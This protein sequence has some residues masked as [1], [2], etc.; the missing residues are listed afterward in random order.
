MKD[1]L[2]Q[3]IDDL[4]Q[5]N[6]FR[7]PKGEF[8]EGWLS[9]SSN[10]YLGLAKHPAVVEAAIKATQKYGVGAGASR[11]A[12]GNYPLYDEFE[13]KIAAYKGY[14]AACVFGSGYLTNIGVIQA[15]VGEKD[16]I[17]AD[18]LSH[19]CI[20]DGARLSGAKL[21]RFKHNDPKHLYKLLLDHR[22]KFKT[23]LVVTEEIFSMDGDHAP[24]ESLKKV[25]VE[26]GATL[27]VDGAHS[28]YEPSKQ[29]NADIYV[30]TMSKALGGYGGYVCGS[31]TFIEYIKTA[32]R[33]LIYSTALPPSVL[34]AAIKSLEVIAQEKPYLKTLENAKYLCSLL[35]V[36]FSNSSIIPII[37]GAEDAALRFEKLLYSNK[38]L[39]SAIRP[40]TV[41]PNT[42]RLRVSVTA[43]HKNEELENLAK[44]LKT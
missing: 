25:C 2:Q 15:L 12:G 44:L 9:F 7:A 35:G 24:L 27:M 30:G 43:N 29:H 21:L 28:L 31:K 8:G 10:D 17:I 3:K 19:A 22:E 37:L 32:A 13:E 18:K 39:V 41:P 33:S 23:V 42:A 20:I 1:L 4:K 14:E 6:L 38:M 36:P 11:I 26:F 16:A 5:K 40:P 34:A